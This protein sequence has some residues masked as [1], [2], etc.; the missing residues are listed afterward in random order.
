[1]KTFLM[2]IFGTN[3]IYG[4]RF[5]Y[6]GFKLRNFAILNVGRNF[7]FHLKLVIFVPPEKGT[8]LIKYL[9]YP[10]IRILD[11]KLLMQ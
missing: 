9:K 1:V 11:Q 7:V 5:C 8:I 4:G 10:K 3:F 6:G 2:R